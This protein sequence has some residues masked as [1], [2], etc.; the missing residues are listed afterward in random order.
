M[1]KRLFATVAG[2]FMAS[3]SLVHAGSLVS[4]ILTS[5]T[6][7]IKFSIPQTPTPLACALSYDCFSVS[8]VAVTIDG[9]TDASAI[10]SFYTPSNGGGLT[11][12]EGSTT[13]INNDGPGDEQLFSGTLGKPTLETFSN[14]QLV[15]VDAYSP[16]LDES[17]L[18]NGAGTGPSAPEPKTY[19]LVLGGFAVIALTL[20]RRRL[21]VSRPGCRDTRTSSCSPT[22]LVNEKEHSRLVSGLVV[23]RSSVRTSH[24]ANS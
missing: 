16:A 18:L 3:A 4:Y 9:V 15:G 6:D 1:K 14:L 2:A 12:V 7:T 20:R 13:E 5:G 19:A 11:I 24:T 10:V 22:P 21:Q 8:P 17:F 23:G